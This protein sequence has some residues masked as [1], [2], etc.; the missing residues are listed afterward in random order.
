MLERPPCR[1]RL[2][3]W[4]LL[5]PA[6]LPVFSPAAASAA[7]TGAGAAG[8]ARIDLSAASPEAR[9]AIEAA[10]A[11]AAAAASGT[12]SARAEAWGRLGMLYLHERLLDAA[13]PCFK[14][15]QEAQPDQMRWSYYLA[16][17][18]QK[19]GDL[20]SAEANLQKAMRVREGNLPVALRLAGVLAD[21]GDAKAAEELYNSALQ[22]PYGVAAAYAGLG[23]L[24]LARGEA[25]QAAEFFDKALAAQPEA[26]ALHHQASL[27]L[28]AAGDVAGSRAQEALA[29]TREVT[30]PDPLLAQL[31]LL[32]RN[33]A[34]LASDD[35]K[36]DN[37]RRTVAAQPDDAAGR[38]ALAQALVAAG[39]L[40][41]AQ[42][43]YEEVVR[44]GKAEARDYLELGSI[45]ADRQRDAAAGVADLE[46]ALQLDPRLYL[47]HQRLAH[48]LLSLGKA[49]EAIRHLLAALEIEPGL[50]VARLQLARTYFNLEQLPEAF[51]AV[52]ELLRREPA[53]FEA[54]LMRGRILAG[55][56]KPAEAR[57][58]FE[59]V[60]A[61]GAAAP[62]QRAEGF[63]SLGLVHQASSDTESAIGDFRKALEQ[64]SSHVSTLSAL[65]AILAA[66]GDVE[67]A[68]PLYQRLASLQPENLEV[69]YRLAA[70]QMQR[71]DAQAAQVLFEE[72]YRAEPKVP[73]FIVTSA[74]LLS[75]LGQTDAGIARLDQALAAQP[76]K[77][78]R[79]R[80]LASRGRIES[81]AGR[82]DAAVASY[83]QAMQLGDTPQ[84]HL[85][86]AQALAL[87]N[88]YP[89]AVQ[90]YDTY[91]KAR[92]Q[93]EQTHFARAM[94]L[95]WAG[96][97]S[98]ARDRL[99]DVTAVSNNVPLTHLLARLLASAPD[100][101]VRNG[102]R[103][104]QI[105]TAVFEAERNPAHGET[106]ALAMAAA[107]HFPEALVLQKRLLAE[108][109]KAKFDAGFIVRVQKNLARFEKNE[110]VV[111]DW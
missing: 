17:V 49:P 108:A 4:L 68:V 38:R 74:L 103:A 39:E 95:I 23:R 96:R 31:D 79:Q 9:T 43:Q 59:R 26:S 46:K 27:A 45:K 100:P 84:L 70:L 10:Q 57:A 21:L 111:S 75:E 7:A 82:V 58:D 89:Q 37:L 42:Q 98:E 41:G 54:V 61:A 104:V 81:R 99:A 110:I 29:G 24:A 60:A 76:E 106:L 67:G 83:R 11:E 35:P 48:M 62:S 93:D 14:T 30:W 78:I 52:S 28:A 16:V 85:E 94:V 63:Y 13:E 47:A 102:E 36:L 2:S 53:N 22:S 97:W 19:K 8:A 90:E 33:A 32:V 77:E 12:P 109:E 105:A 80:L 18:Q 64:D 34:R 73:E 69:K 88:R 20:K 56:N 50:S 25:R 6:L 91:L 40:E 44:R 51:A 86:L 72:L 101:K 92:P 107:G 1:L 55:Q 87:A 71:G 15:A 65:G 3:V 66:R 5:V